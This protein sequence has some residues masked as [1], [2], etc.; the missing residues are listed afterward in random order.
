MIGRDLPTPAPQC[1]PVRRALK[2]MFSVQIPIPLNLSGVRLAAYETP[3]GPANAVFVAAPCQ[4][5]GLPGSIFGTGGSLTSCGC[6]LSIR[7]MSGSGP[8]GPILNGV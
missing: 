7:V 2:N 6:P 4:I 8:F 1:V 3:H 5:H